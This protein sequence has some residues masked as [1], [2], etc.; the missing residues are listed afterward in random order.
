MFVHKNFTGMWYVDDPLPNSVHMMISLSGC[1]LGSTVQ[2]RS[3]LRWFLDNS[4]FLLSVSSPLLHTIYIQ[5]RL[6]H[7]IK[8]LISVTSVCVIMES[9]DSITGDGTEYM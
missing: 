3:T 9:V 5:S 1:A 6:H 2:C 8:E 4:F 7:K